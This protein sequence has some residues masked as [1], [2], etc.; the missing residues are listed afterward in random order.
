MVKPSLAIQPT[1]QITLGRFILCSLFLF[2]CNS[3]CLLIKNMC[4]PYKFSLYYDKKNITKC[5]LVKMDPAQP[6]HKS[7]IL[8]TNLTQIQIP[9]LP[10]WVFTTI[11]PC[12]SKYKKK[13]GIP[14]HLCINH[15]LV[16]LSFL[17][18]IL[19]NMLI[20]T[21]LF[22]VINNKKTQVAHS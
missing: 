5:K 9:A 7:R 10:V 8:D 15:W 17:Q 22:S 13:K 18:A 20:K 3:M 2:Y 1:T 14:I 16:P 6:A 21:T 11:L 19:S 12:N 4:V